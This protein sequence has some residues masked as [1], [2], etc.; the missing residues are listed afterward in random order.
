MNAARAPWT[1]APAESWPVR[2]AAV[3]MVVDALLLIAHVL[4]RSG[5]VLDRD[6]SRL[7]PFRRAALWNGGMDGSL[8]E[9]FGLLQLGAAA[10]LLLWTGLRDRTHH[11]L[12]GWGGVL[13]LVAADDLFRIHERVGAR[14]ALDRLVPSLG[15]TT[16]Q[17][18]GG[19][20]FW[21]V[22][23]LVLVGGLVHLHRGSDAFSR[24]ASWTLLATVTPFV[25]VA[26][27]YVLAGAVLPGRLSGSGGEVAAQLRVTV[28]LLTMTMLLI[29]GMWSCTA[30]P[31]S[32][33]SRSGPTPPDSTSPRTAPLRC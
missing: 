18:I 16:A 1:R 17:E 24:S 23:G 26:V 31:G 15:A 10:A 9:L 4:H 32:R 14:F 33:T 27:G 5:A 6:G 12:A 29:Q 25:L 11:V 2:I 28:K 8:L 22:S 19:L 20:A 30:I 7:L 21:A 3:V 13:L